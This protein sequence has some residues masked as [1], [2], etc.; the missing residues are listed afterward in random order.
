[1]ESFVV[2]VPGRAGVE[3]LADRLC[4]IGVSVG[5]GR[6]TCVAVVMGVFLALD[7]W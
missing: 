3:L 1:M 5:E 6:V 4:F 7:N 2:K